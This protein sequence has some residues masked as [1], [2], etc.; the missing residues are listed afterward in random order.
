MLEFIEGIGRASV[1]PF[2]VPIAVWTGLA[3]AAALVPG[4]KRGLHPISG[5]RLHQALLLAL[6]T[7]VVAAPWV[8]ELWPPA[9]APIGPLPSASGIEIGPAPPGAV[10]LALD[11]GRGVDI[12]WAL[13]G[14]ATVAVLLLAAARLAVLMGDL[15]QLRRLRLATPRVDEAAPRRTLRELAEH[16]GVRRP[17]VLLEGPPG[18][19]PMTFG[20]WRPVVVLPRAQLDAPDS[21]GTALAHELIHVRRADS[22][23]ALLDCLTSAAFGFHPLVRLL[24]R[25]IERCRE[26]SCDAEVLAR[27]VV[28]PAAYAELLAHTH[29]P[30]QFPLPAIAAG[31]SAPSLTLK[32]RL[33]TMKRFADTRL[34]FRRRMGLVVGTG[35]LF[36]VTA[37]LG[38]CAGDTAGD[39]S[40][41]DDALAPV[42][43]LEFGE[44]AL[45]RYAIPLAIDHEGP[46]QYTHMSE[47][48]AQEE[49]ARFEIQVQYLREQIEETGEAMGQFDTTDGRFDR[50]EEMY[51]AERFGLLRSMHAQAVKRSETAKLAYETQKRMQGRP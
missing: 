23:S 47:E 48:R 26:M 24:R 42:A 13:L 36:L 11:P 32:E 44:A 21:L 4:L 39:A 43:E 29:T 31:L 46:V 41:R 1:W 3:G 35:L 8:P 27:G 15:R 6:P 38:A 7:S 22:L 28:R 51:L 20:V 19:T 30:T 17:V 45:Q 9:A 33:E 49:L 50:R 25:R 37:T 40:V 16:L 18:S 10:P 34:T 12:A 14:A 5:Y 2:W